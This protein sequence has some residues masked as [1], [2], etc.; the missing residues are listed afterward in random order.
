MN[1]LVIEHKTHNSNKAQGNRQLT[2]PFH[3][4][5]SFAEFYTNFCCEFV[6]SLS[7]FV[8]QITRSVHQINMNIFLG[9]VAA[10]ICKLDS[11]NI[12]IWVLVDY[13]L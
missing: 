4:S 11:F 5:Q 10:V 8:D 9:F 2:D 3:R 1:V 7:L 12:R 6:Y 13:N